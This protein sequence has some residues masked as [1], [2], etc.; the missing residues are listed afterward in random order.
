MFGEDQFIGQK[1][2][3]WLLTRLALVFAEQRLS[4][5]LL[6]TF[7]PFRMDSECCRALWQ[8]RHLHSLIRPKLRR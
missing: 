8:W 1:M 2:I 6:W 4:I 3:L 7:V 5:A